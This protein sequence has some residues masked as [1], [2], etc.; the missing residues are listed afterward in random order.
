[1]SLTWSQT[2]KTDFLVTRLTVLLES[3]Y[4][5]SKSS[6]KPDSDYVKAS[7][8]GPDTV[9]VRVAESAE[10]F[11]VTCLGVYIPVVSEAGRSS[12]VSVSYRTAV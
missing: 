9:S 6:Y 1:M 2:P 3:P 12:A 4:P 11:E 5:L 7:V 10:W 8:T